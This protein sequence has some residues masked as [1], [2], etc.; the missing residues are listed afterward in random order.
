MTDN[1]H[2]II[3]RHNQAFEKNFLNKLF[4]SFK[5]DPYDISIT[6]IWIEVIINNVKL[7]AMI[8]T[9][10]ENS[11]F[12]QKTLDKIKLSCPIFNNNT[13]DAEVFINEKK[14]DCIFVVRKPTM[15]FHC[16]IIL[17]FDFLSINKIYIDF[18]DNIIIGPNFCQFIN[19]N[20]MCEQNPD[21]D[22]IN[23]SIN[24]NENIT[25]ELSRSEKYQKKINYFKYFHENIGN[26]ISF[27]MLW[28]RVKIRGNDILALVDTGAPYSSLTKQIIDKYNLNEIVDYSIKTKSQYLSSKIG[29][30]HGFVWNIDITIDNYVFSNNFRINNLT[31]LDM[32]I[33][34]D[35]LIRNN[36]VIDFNKRTLIF[37]DQFSVD[38][39]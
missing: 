30:D 27:N 2:K 24:V 17:G 25:Q 38:F 36:V 6:H 33:G 10:C 23:P 20:K 5:L 11:I 13:Y 22:N 21:G 34:L 3:F 32:I 7:V 28:I 15:I 4:S 9:G 14:H 29:V 1:K 35:F 19:F 39:L 26:S 18:T 8:D 31:F 37:N 16:D 12:F